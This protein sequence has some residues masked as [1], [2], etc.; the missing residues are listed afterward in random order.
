MKIRYNDPYELPFEL[1][2]PDG[3]PEAIKEIIE[4]L[5]S[6]AHPTEKG[7]GFV[8]P[9]KSTMSRWKRFFFGN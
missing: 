2:I 5:T 4:Y 6:P 8:L 3:E 7:K 9:T 1:I